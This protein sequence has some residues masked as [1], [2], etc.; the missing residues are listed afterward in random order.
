MPYHYDAFIKNVLIRQSI[1]MYI[2]I[3]SVI[4]FQMSLAIYNIIK[5]TEGHD[6]IFQRSQF[7]ALNA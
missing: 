5:F 7:L 2:Y 1:N 4:L 6:Q 3:C